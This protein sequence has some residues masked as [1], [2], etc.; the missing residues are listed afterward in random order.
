MSKLFVWLILSSSQLHRVLRSIAAREKLSIELG[1]DYSTKINYSD[2]SKDSSILSDEEIGLR[3]R[4]D[5]IVVIDGNFIPVEQKTGKIPNEP[6][7]SHKIQLLAYIHLIESSTGTSPPY[8]ALRYGSEIAFPIEWNDEHR[9][10]LMEHLKEI[11][12]LTV[13]GGAERNHQ[14]IGKC[15]NCSRNHVCT[16]PLN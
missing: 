12:R 13:E 1:I 8:G 14:Q 15:R 3:G 2:D 10:L 4:P 6:H 9:D 7:L 16:D 5:Q 11:Q